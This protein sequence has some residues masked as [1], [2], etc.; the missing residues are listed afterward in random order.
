MILDHL[1][2]KDKIPGH[3]ENEGNASSPLQRWLY[4]TLQSVIVTKELR[5]KGKFMRNHVTDWQ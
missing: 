3:S 1:D 4:E 5:L 2:N